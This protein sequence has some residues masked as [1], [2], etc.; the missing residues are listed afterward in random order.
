MTAREARK[1]QRRENHDSGLT[2]YGAISLYVIAKLTKKREKKR[3]KEKKREM[4]MGRIK[5]A[6]ISP[7]QLLLST[8]TRAHSLFN[9]F[10]TNCLRKILRQLI[11]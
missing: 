7:L 4:D 11:L 8:Y 9:Q 2:F 3:K 5:T 1:K 10:S 6:K